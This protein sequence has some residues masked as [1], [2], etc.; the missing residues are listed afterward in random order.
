MPPPCPARAAVG[1]SGGRQGWPGRRGAQRVGDAPQDGEAGRAVLGPEAHEDGRGDALLGQ[2]DIGD[3]VAAEAADRGGHEVV[4]S[5]HPRRTKPLA[6]DKERYK[7]RHLIESFFAKIKEFK[8]I[9]MRSDKTDRSFAA[10]I[11]L[12]AAVIHSR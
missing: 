5:Q 8:R 6:I 12:A 10:M 7:R 3:V 2:V 9:A 11:H 4:I 1:G